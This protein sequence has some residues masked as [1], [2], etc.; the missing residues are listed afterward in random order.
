MKPSVELIT[1]LILAAG[2]LALMITSIVLFISHVWKVLKEN[3][4]WPL[5]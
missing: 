5:L 3:K 1:V 2:V 4:I